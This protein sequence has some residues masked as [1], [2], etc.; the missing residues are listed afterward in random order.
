MGRVPSLR[1]LAQRAP[2]MHG[3][4]APTLQARS[5]PACGG[6]DKHGR[7]SRLT[8][9]QVDDLVAYLLTL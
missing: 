3:G 5:D 7:T 4:C 2:Y 9:D 6:G 8:A 1:G